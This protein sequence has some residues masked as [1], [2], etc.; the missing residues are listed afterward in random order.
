[1]DQTEIKIGD[2]APGFALKDHHGKETK[3]SEAL[4]KKVVLGFHP[5][6][7][8]PVC[9]R[10]MKD[11]E[12][13]AGRFDELGAVAFGLSVDSA[14]CKHAWAASLGV[15]RTRL[16][17]DFWPHGDVAR[18]F[19]VFNETEGFS[20]RAVFVLDG[21]GTVRFKK[22]YPISQVPDIT[23]IIAAVEKI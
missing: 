10:Q 1:M 9:A 21:K 6:A 23:E 4:G 15:T 14:P 16:L 12:A 18:R 8:T 2:V 11:L 20:N 3:L 17:S 7:W 5:L 22:V 13:S 19:G